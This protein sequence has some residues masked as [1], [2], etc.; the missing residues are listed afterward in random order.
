AGTKLWTTGA[1]FAHAMVVLART[2]GT[3]EDRHAGLSQLIVDLPADGVEIRPIV[4]IDG[5]HHFNEVAFD[6]AVLQV[7]SL[8]G[9]RGAGWRRSNRGEGWPGWPAC[10]PKGS[11]IPR[12]SPSAAGRTKSSAR[13]SR[14]G[15]G[16]GERRSALGNPLGRRRDADRPQPRGGV[17]PS[18]VEGPDRRWISPAGRARGGGRQRWRSAGA[19]RGGGSARL[20][21]RGGTGRGSG[22]PGRL[23]AVAG[24]TRHAGSPDGRLARRSPGCVSAV[25]P[26]AGTVGP[27]RGPRGDLGPGRRHGPG[28]RG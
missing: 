10:S 27:A 14:A 3:P 2:D 17:R 16:S 12:R 4:T 25:R 28:R 24:R 18:A 20:S 1:H 23:A 8:L 15:W 7:G 19:R 5:E 21:R 11:C 6:G 9:Q 26:G 22:L 13:L